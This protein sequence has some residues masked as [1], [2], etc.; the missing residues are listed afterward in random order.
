MCSHIGPNGLKCEEGEPVYDSDIPGERG[1]P[2][3]SCEDFCKQQQA[4]GVFINPK[5]VMKVK[6]CDEIES[7][8]LKRCD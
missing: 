5:C 3:Q 4:L 2:N 6:S 1:I 7:A 8:R